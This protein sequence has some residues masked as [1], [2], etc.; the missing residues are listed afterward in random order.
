MAAK[1][2]PTAAPPARYYRVDAIYIKV[3][4][5]DGRE[6]RYPRGK[7]VAEADLY[8]P[9]RY[10]RMLV[11]AGDLTVVPAPAPAEESK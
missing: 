10:L 6:I 1:D 11:A 2:E 4:P 3:T 5:P 9:P 7:V 8:T